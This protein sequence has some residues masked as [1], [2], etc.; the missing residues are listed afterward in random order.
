MSLES[1]APRTADGP[2]W[3][4]ALKILVVGLLLMFGAWA[5]LRI[6]VGHRTL[7]MLAAGGLTINSLLIWVLFFSRLPGTIRMAAASLVF[8]PILFVRLEGCDGDLRPIFGWRWQQRADYALANSIPVAA[9]KPDEP[10]APAVDLA[11]TTP[12]D[13]PR[14]LGAS[15]TGKVTGV[16]LSRDW[17]TQ[18]PRELWRRPIGAGW[19]GFSVVGDFAVTQEQR[20]DVEAVVCYRWK[21]GEPVWIHTNPGRHDTAM[22]GI[23]PRATPTIDRGVVYT[24]GAEGL[25]I[26]L[27]GV[28]GR[29]L[30]SHN[31]L[32]ENKAS[33]PDWGK[34]CS[35]LVVGNLVIVSIGSDS[36][37]LAA[38]DRESGAEIWKTGNDRSS[39]ASPVLAHIGGVEQVVM[40]GSQTVVGH[41]LSTGKAL[42]TFPW[43]GL[44]PKVPNPIV[45]N[46]HQ[47]L[48]SSGYGYGCKLLDVTREGDAW[49]VKELWSTTQL[50]PK[51]THPILF[52]G[53]IYSLD[54][55][56][57]M[58]CLDL[59]TGKRLWKKGRYG[60][61]QLL[62][63]DD[64]LVVMAENG[65]VALVEPNPKEHREL[66]RFKALKDR[67][68][69]NPTLV[70]NHLLVRN[71]LEAACFELPVAP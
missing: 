43:D 41:E 31:I 36:A 55:G 1:N 60:H 54:D 53:H 48:V 24:L 3:N 28:D 67:T 69:N 27:N 44:A 18:P 33:V 30:W 38:Y 4:T 51:F 2:R 9:V 17:K 21:S 26:A 11:T 70:G 64:L 42:W 49:T 56:I 10:V 59:S 66:G 25:L 58:V 46:D 6:D 15:G 19:S 16:K 68:W 71:D 8:I 37:S 20:G 5:G 34:S 62:L 29:E 50:N 57:A 61:G 12:L 65:E 32:E 14:F 63:V 47:L 52:D 23:G 39:Y 35:P 13:Y 22:G 40:L 7:G 45:I